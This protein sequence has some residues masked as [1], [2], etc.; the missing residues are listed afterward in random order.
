MQTERRI[1]THCPDGEHITIV[2]KNHPESKYT[3]KNIGQTNSVG[4]IYFQRSIFLECGRHSC[5]CDSNSLV[6]IHED[7]KKN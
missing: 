6:H 1:C 3:S 2:C 5:D 4:E 7:N